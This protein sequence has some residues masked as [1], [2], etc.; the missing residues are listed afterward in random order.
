M[1]ACSVQ[2]AI[3]SATITTSIDHSI[4]RGAA[5]LKHTSSGVLVQRQKVLGLLGDLDRNRFTI[6]TSLTL[7][8]QLSLDAALVDA[9]YRATPSAKTEEL[10][11]Q[12]V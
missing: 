2:R 7:L 9:R 4:V 3:E 5:E 12:L 11:Q 1:D 6:L 10:V 8:R